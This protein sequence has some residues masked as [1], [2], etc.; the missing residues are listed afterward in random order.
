MKPR[1]RFNIQPK[2]PPH[3]PLAGDWAGVEKG[4]GYEFWGLRRYLPGDNCGHIDWKARARSGELY[5][6]EFLQDSAYTL[7]LLVDVSASMGFGDK[8]SLAQDIAASLAY[9]ALQNSNPCGLLLFADRVIDYQAPNASARQ[10][11]RLRSM[12]QKSRPVDCHETRLQSAIDHLTNL[13]PSCLG[14]ILSDFHDR[15]GSLNALH[16]VAASDRSV[17]HEILALHLLEEVEWQLPDLTGQVPLQ[18]LETGEELNLDLAQQQRYQV[19][20][21]RWRQHRIKQLAR[22]GIDSTVII[23]GQ[24]NVQ[25]KINAFFARR[26]AARV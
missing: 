5:V 18:D 3:Q 10:Y 20:V 4:T 1:Y 8:R 12:L 11:Q 21:H 25:E 13:L 26:L 17:A 22:A 23:N 15:P 6:R 16:S 7:M 24:D 2:Y 14:V 19:A 9:S